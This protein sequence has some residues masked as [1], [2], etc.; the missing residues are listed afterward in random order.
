V[1]V[2]S[3]EFQL[4]SHDK[5]IIIVKA[6]VNDKGPFDFAVDTGASVTVIS[7]RTAE[8]LG[9]SNEPSTPKR[10]QCCGGG[11][12]MSLRRVESVQVGEA[13]QRNLEVA[14][15]DLSSISKCLGME[16]EG[17]IGHNFMKSYMII[18]DYP[19]KT[20]SFETA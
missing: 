11:I 13:E 8:K 17:I 18:I 15:M 1:E 9:I 2:S 14:L 7:K 12:D 16:L 20:I 6:T 10:G 19:K 5:P 3:I 4:A